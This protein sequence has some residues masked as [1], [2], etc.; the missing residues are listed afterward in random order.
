ML[1]V[2]V[3]YCQFKFIYISENKKTKFPCLCTETAKYCISGVEKLPYC[4]TRNII[5][6][7]NS[8]TTICI[9]K[10][11]FLFQGGRNITVVSYKS[12]LCLI[13]YP[14]KIYCTCVMSSLK[15]RD[16]NKD[17]TR[18][19]NPLNLIIKYDMIII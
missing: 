7:Y 11:I 12:K 8:N 14:N 3:T 13:Y 17:Y 6:L 18:L 5:V 19:E 16:L 9:Q 10:A 1:V 15:T 4:I 2:F